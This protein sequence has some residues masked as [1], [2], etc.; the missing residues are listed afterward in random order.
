MI[1]LCGGLFTVPLYALLQ[2]RSD[3]SHRSRVVAANNIVNAIFIVV[4]GAVSAAMLAVHLTVPQIFL[5]VGVLNAVAAIVVMR[6]HPR[7]HPEDAAGDAVPLRLPRRG[8]G[9]RELPQAGERAVVVVNHV[10][11]LDGLLLAAFLP[12]KPTFAVHTEIA[13]RRGGSSRSSGC[14]T[15]SRSI[16]PTRWRPRR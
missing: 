5:V 14:S 13:H 6:L 9:A 3:E 1:A 7:R 16:R 11:F 4:S 10:S 8:E 2:A 15:P 12:G